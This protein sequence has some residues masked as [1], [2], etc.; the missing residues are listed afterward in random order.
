M[1]AL[2][3]IEKEIIHFLRVQ[4]DA[5]N[6]YYLCSYL[7]DCYQQDP[8]PNY[9]VSAECLKKY[10]F[11]EPSRLDELLDL[12]AEYGWKYKTPFDYKQPPMI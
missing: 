10:V 11:V 8:H 7:G 9:M 1:Y 3:V 5:G 6:G 4:C 12:Y 2:L